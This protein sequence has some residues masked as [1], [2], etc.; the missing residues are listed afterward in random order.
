MEEYNILCRPLFCHIFLEKGPENLLLLINILLGLQGKAQ[1]RG[2]SSSAIELVRPDNRHAFTMV[3]LHGENEDGASLLVAIALEPPDRSDRAMIP[4]MLAQ[5]QKISGTGMNPSTIKYGISISSWYYQRIRKQHQPPPL[6]TKLTD[7]STLFALH[8][9]N[10]CSY[11][12][13]FPLK[14][15]DDAREQMMYF[16][17][18]AGMYARAQSLDYAL[19]AFLKK[20]S[21]APLWKAFLHEVGDEKL[22]WE[23]L[24]YERGEHDEATRTGEA[25][26]TGRNEGVQEAREFIA[27]ELA[28]EGL[29]A[30]SLAELLSLI[31][32]GEKK[33]A[34]L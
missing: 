26:R 12:A 8:V 32:A 22:Y 7:R 11:N 24:E 4:L 3:T 27:G 29:D 5:A 19:P 17:H 31:T 6:Y 23:I 14:E 25:E 34:R 28:R 21:P 15:P 13:P 16:L 2:V 1:M 30:E 33:G 9:F 10:L 18:Y 20:G